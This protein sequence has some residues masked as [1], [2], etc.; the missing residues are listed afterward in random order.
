MKSIGRFFFRL[1]VLLGLLWI[2]A[3][4]FLGFT[5]LQ[6]ARWANPGNAPDILREWWMERTDASRIAITR[7]D[8]TKTVISRGRYGEVVTEYGAE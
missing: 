2:L 8:G 3:P 4:F 1:A 6:A 7:R 5:P